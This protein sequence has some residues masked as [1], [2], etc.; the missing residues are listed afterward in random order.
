MKKTK[1]QKNKKLPNLSLLNELFYYDPMS[2]ILSDFV[3]LEEVGWQ[4]KK[5]YRHVR[6]NKQVYKVHRICFYMHHRRDPGK[7]VIDHINGVTDDNSIFN[8][9]AVKHRENIKNTATKRAKG[10]VPRLEP[11]VHRLLTVPV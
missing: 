10:I 3:T 8:L 1:K 9:R 4:C 2:G 11:G 5:G 6:I 7:L